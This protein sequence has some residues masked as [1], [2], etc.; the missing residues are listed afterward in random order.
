MLIAHLR[1]ELDR[2]AGEGLQ[3]RRRVVQMPC[4]P[5]QRLAGQQDELLS[6]CS[7]DYMGLAQHPVLIQ[8][9]AEGA[10]RWGAGSGASHLVSGHMQVHEDLENAFA[11]W[12]QAHIPQAQGLLFGSG[13]MANMA[14]M[15]ALGDGNTTILADKLNH[16]SLIDGCRLAKAEVRRYPHGDVQQLE[17]LLQR[18]STPVKLIVTD[19]V[20]SMD[21]D[22]ADLP[23]LLRLAEAYDAW[24]VIDDAHALGV[25]GAHGHGSLE[26]FGLHSERLIW[27]GTLGKA[28]GVGGAVVV[29]HE[30][31]IDWLVQRARPYIYTTGMP[32]SLA[33]ALLASMVLVE[34]EEGMARRAHLQALIGRLRAGLAALLPAHP[35]WSLP[36]SSTAIQPLVVGSN[37]EALR[38]SAALERAGIWVPAIRPPTVPAG[39]ARLRFTLS[40]AHTGEQLDRLL[41]VLNGLLEESREKL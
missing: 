15:T 21:G 5:E 18:C 39:T 23:A 7:N 22:I 3:R 20:F 6:F 27:M 26:H 30:T 24:L 17:R 32:P 2:L 19:A 9:L 38:L 33:Q 36:E 16:A 37:A 10:Q 12:Q 34:S 1:E 40:A 41:G 11:R 8:A 31:I 29:A 25:L 28:M 13:F 4:G 14:L 35:H